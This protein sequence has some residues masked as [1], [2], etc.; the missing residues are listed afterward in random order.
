MTLI[1]LLGLEDPVRPEVPGAVQVCC[2]V[3]QCVAVCCSVLQA[4]CNT[5]APSCQMPYRCVAVCGSVW[6]CVFC[7]LFCRP[8]VPGAVQ[9]CMYVS[10]VCLLSYVGFFCGSLSYVGFF[11]GSLLLSTLI[12][13]LGGCAGVPV[14]LF[15]RSLSQVSFVGLFCWSLLLVSLALLCLGL[16]CSYTSLRSWSSRIQCAPKC[17]APFRCVCSSLLYISFPLLVSFVGS[18]GF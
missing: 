16:F 17:R 14:G 5:V 10:S 4:H 7:S 13:L 18:F 1:A 9:V 11:C 8:K 12:A 15:L 6:Q 2:S 3:L